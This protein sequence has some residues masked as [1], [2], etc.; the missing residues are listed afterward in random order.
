MSVRASVT[1]AGWRQHGT[2]G[3]LWDVNLLVPVVSPWLG[4][5]RDLLISSVEFRKDDGGSTTALELTLPDAFMGEGE[6]GTASGGDAGAN[7]DLW[8]GGSIT[9]VL[10]RAGGIFL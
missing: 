2:R 6:G 10:E 5:D 3:P 9:G 7:G 4:I 1:V 8:S